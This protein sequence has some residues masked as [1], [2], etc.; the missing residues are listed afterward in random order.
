MMEDRFI[1]YKGHKVHYGV[2][3]NAAEGKPV[4]LLHG[5]TEAIFV[6]ERLSRCLSQRGFY[7]VA[8]DLAGHG[9]TEMF[10]HS[11]TMELQAEIVQAVMQSETIEKAVM[12]GH[13]M[14]GYV[15][16]A[17]ACLYPRQVAGVGFFHS[18]PAADT[19][20]GR[21]NRRRTLTLLEAG[22][23]SFM[24][25]FTADLFAPDTAQNYPDAVAALQ[26][27]SKNMGAEA[28]AA[29]QRGMLER[30]SRLAVY[31]L[32]VPFLFIIGKQDAKA[33]VPK[34]MAQSLLPQQSY[35][36][37][38]PCGHMGMYECPVQTET[39]V[40]GFASVCFFS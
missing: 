39:L 26:A 11:H 32:P 1:D 31:D 18:N 38:L 8:I 21:E 20:A 6:W 4:V 23:T 3:G 9:R 28:I 25:Q 5:F 33:D 30:P 34:L 24:N 7:A 35:V 14:G 37:L 12:I 16:A 22:H 10:A 19:E 36:Q 13:S 15:A 2:A 40:C 27:S 29:A 17:F